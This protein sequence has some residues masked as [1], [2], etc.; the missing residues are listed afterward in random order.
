MWGRVPDDGAVFGGGATP[1]PGPEMNSVV[2]GGPGLVAVGYNS[3]GAAV[4]TSTDGLIWERVPQRGRLRRLRHDLGGGG[5]SGPGRRRLRRPEV[6]AVWTSTDGLAWERVPYDEA[7]FGG[8]V[9][10]QLG[11][12]GGSGS[13]RRRLRQLRLR[14]GTRWCGRLS[15]GWP[16]GG[17]PTTRRSSAAPPYE[18][19][20][21]GGSGSG[22]RRLPDS[23]DEMHEV[24]SQTRRTAR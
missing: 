1:G 15:M 17:F 7:V 4:W 13:G 14:L 11:G 24:A 23:D 22:R 12:G 6:R 5:G 9:A 16:G 8:S 21:G 2:A 3:G 19:G 18:L 20:G 10:M